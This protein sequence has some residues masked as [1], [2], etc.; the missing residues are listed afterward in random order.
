LTGPGFTLPLVTAGAADGNLTNFLAT[1]TLDATPN[2]ANI[3]QVR[4]KDNLSG[5]KYWE[6]NISYN[7]AA[8]TWA[9]NDPTTTATT[10]TLTASP[11]SP[12]TAPASPVTLNALVAPASNGTVKFME[13]ATQLGSTQNVTTASGA[14]SVNIGAPAT[15]DHTYTAVFTPTAGTLVSGSTSAGLLYHVG[16]PQ[17]GT[18]TTLAVNPGTGVADGVNPV[19][20]TSNVTTADSSNTTGTVT[21][22]EGATTLGTSPSG[23]TTASYTFS[24]TALAAGSHTVTATFNPAD[25]A[26]APSTS[27]PQ[28]FALT[29]PTCPAGT[30]DAQTVTADIPAGTLVIATPYTAAA[31][32]DVPLVLDPTASF[33]TGQAAFNGIHVTDTRSGNQ[34]WTLKAQSSSL[35]NGANADNGQNVGLTALA[36]D[37]GTPSTVSQAAGNITITQNPAAAPV[38][39]NPLDPGSL[40]LGGT[41]HTLVH[42]N[43]GIGTITFKGTLTI[44]APSNLPAGT[45]T[46]TITFTVG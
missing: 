20:F 22:K 32:L 35:T 34:P 36:V 42:A 10:T 8:G 21:F 26:Y 43:L 14:A 30:C 23:P 9:V 15:G 7:A 5:T 46:G 39:T 6:T 33:F 45:Y 3:I 18:T 17:I 2:Y 25:P 24:T 37:A 41:Q 38:V 27:A 44:N 12:Q 40:G 29:A 1:A 16:A 31:P 19:T 4:V 13:G 11:P 28:T